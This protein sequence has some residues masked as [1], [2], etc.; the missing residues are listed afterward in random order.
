MPLL[1]N[2]LVKS[3]TN[4]LFEFEKVKPELITTALD[5]L[6]T[7]A[8]TA[9]QTATDPKEPS[10]WEAL[11]EALEGTHPLAYA[12]GVV[13]HLAHVADEPALRAAYSENLPRITEFWSSL[14]QNTALYQKYKTLADSPEYSALSAPQQ[15][16]IQNALRDFK[17]GGAELSEDKKQRFLEIQEETALLSKDFSEHVLDATEAFS[18]YTE[19]ESDLS[20]LPPDIKAKAKEAAQKAQRTGWTLGLQAPTYIAVQQYADQRELREHFYKAYVTRASELAQQYGSGGLELNNSALILSLL[21]LRAE[22][23]QLLDFPNFSALSL[24]TKMAK[25][26]EEVMQ[27]LDDLAQRA[28][29]YAEKDWEDLQIFASEY[30]ELSTLE[31]WDIAYA[32]EK[33]REERYSFSEQEVRQYFQETKVI[34]GLFEAAERLFD[35]QI[36]YVPCSPALLWH[37]DVRLFKIE[38]AQGDL[39]AHFY[40][41]LYARDGKRSGAWMN[42]ACS[43]TQLSNGKIE[44]PV[45][46]LVC[47][48]SSPVDNQPVLLNHEEVLT[49]FHEFGHG[50]HHMLTSV[51]EYEV[52]G[53]AGVEWD[54]VELPSQFMENFCWEWEV[55]SAL[56]AHIDT[57]EPL[58]QELFQKMVAARHFQSGL[59]MLRQIVFSAFDMQVHS[60]FDPFNPRGNQTIIEF[61]KEIHEHYHVLPQSEISRW[62]NT[63]SHIFSG[64]Y[65]AGYYSYKWAELL[66]SD[67]YSAFEEVAQFTHSVLNQETGLRFYEEILS[68]GGS[69]PALESFKAFRG[70]PPQIDALLRHNGMSQ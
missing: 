57:Q 5:A 20:G 59:A 32:S 22:E 36:A 14:A 28:R 45:A 13:D 21:Q 67:A 27:F 12:W 42:H 10:T 37:P 61:S 33:L 30:L 62:P 35:I 47:N 48:F 64:G 2:P 23:A 9:L 66:S 70:R 38:N 16:V 43:R 65:A 56:S 7:Q 18:F 58:P 31:P 11:K 52:S 6:L 34:E 26:P 17:L 50:L 25:S 49:L 46:Y 4:S 68:V 29:P 51:E 63:F 44:L 24:A 40:L 60:Q 69:R 15:K 54:A 8:Q 19:D 3:D 41:D 39:L 53:I 55:I 1:K